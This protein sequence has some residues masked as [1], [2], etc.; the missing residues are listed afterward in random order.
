MAAPTDPY[1]AFKAKPGSRESFSLAQQLGMPAGQSD[2]SGVPKPYM[3]QTGVRGL[4]QG[5]THSTGLRPGDFDPISGGYNTSTGQAPSAAAWQAGHP[6]ET[7]TMNATSAAS[8]DPAND[9]GLQWMKEHGQTPD[10]TSQAAASSGGVGIGGGGGAA[11]TSTP[12]PSV[13][14]SMGGLQTAAGGLNLPPTPDALNSGA[15]APL[16]GD[17]GYR[18]PPSLQALL[19][20][21]PY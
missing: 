17:L 2:T 16:R 8:R 14:P 21:K 13:S 18:T 7:A 20:G 3:A 19:S 6:E 15:G 4:A 10:T 9:S 12:A 5:P 1:A 11:G